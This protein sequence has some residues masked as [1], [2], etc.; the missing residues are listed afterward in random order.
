MGCCSLALIRQTL[1]TA[2]P[3]LSSL[4]DGMSLGFSAIILAQLGNANSTIHITTEQGSTIASI[5]TLPIIISFALSSYLMNVYG[6]RL[7]N[8]IL[9][10]PFVLGWIIISLSTQVWSIYV[11]SIVTL[12]IIIS[13]ALSSYLMNVYGRRF[14]NLILCIS[15][16]MNVYGRRLTNLILCVPFV[17]G[18][19]IIS[20]STQVWS[21]YVGRF[22]TGLGAILASSSGIVYIAEVTDPEYRGFFLALRS[23]AG[24]SGFFVTHLLGTFLHWKWAAAV[25]ALVPLVSLVFV[26]FT[27][28]SPP[29]LASKGFT[30]EA[31]QASQW[32]RGGE[33][34][35]Q[36]KSELPVPHTHKL[37]IREWKK[38]ILLRSRNTYQETIKLSTLDLG[39]HQRAVIIDALS[40]RNSNLL[41]YA[42][43]ARPIMRCI[44]SLYSGLV[45]H[46]A[47]NMV[48]PRECPRA[49][50]FYTVDLM[51]QFSSD[52]NEYTATI[53]I[54]LVRLVMSTVTC[55][56]VRIIGRRKLAL[57]SCFGTS[58]SLLGLGL[59]LKLPREQVSS[60]IPVILLVSHTIFVFTGLYQL[61]WIMIGE[62]FPQVTREVGN[63]ITT[64]AAYI[65]LFSC[66]KIAP[67]VFN[68]LGIA[69]GFRLY[70]CIVACG[71]AFVYFFLPE[72][73]SKTLKEIEDSFKMNSMPSRPVDKIVGTL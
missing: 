38:N 46:M 48:V 65:M 62:L 35:P 66:V 47:K 33:A 72:T 39:V 60:F 36:I 24:C 30:V 34:D 61:P 10:A 55:A 21:I 13:F 70:G 42:A 1:A 9:C 28:E 71:F 5:V 17:L 14:T 56:L 27:P 52:V 15:Y 7:T 51:S 32:L 58:I 11:A 4:G 29:W 23:L 50:T 18:W 40:G 54:D 69:D 19:I 20:L 67:L 8:L 6:R 2:G 45:L 63:G 16:L 41:K 49:V 68:T 22:I 73:K 26:Y 59:V 64:F 37:T 12:P 53:A 57:F 43:G 25:C 3:N 44:L 31:E